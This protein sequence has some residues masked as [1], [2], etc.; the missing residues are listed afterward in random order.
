MDAVV[1]LTQAVLAV[2]V[3]LVIVFSVRS[4]AKRNRE[5]KQKLESMLRD[6]KNTR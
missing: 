5:N 4:T 6:Y 3:I 2:G 1:G